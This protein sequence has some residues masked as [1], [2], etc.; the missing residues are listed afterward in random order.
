M[1][2]NGLEGRQ[3]YAS[4]TQNP[5]RQNAYGSTMREQGGKYAEAVSAGRVFSITSQAAVAVTDALATTWTGLGVGNPLYSGIQ[6]I[7]ISFSAVG[8]LAKQKAGVIGLEISKTSMTTSL[9]PVN[10]LVGGA[11][12]T[13]LASAGQTIVTPVLWDVLGSFGTAN[14]NTIGAENAQTYDIDGSIVLDPGYMVAPFTTLDST[15]AFLFSFTWEE[16]AR[17][18]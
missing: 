17:I 5:V 11:A 10:R 9:T 15:A 8:S 14:T 12:A 13:G 18:K 6:I 1:L 3:D 7:L 2:L 4:G 16:R